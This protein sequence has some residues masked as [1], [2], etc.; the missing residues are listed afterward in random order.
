MTEPWTRQEQINYSVF[1]KKE[2]VPEYDEVWKALHAF[3]NASGAQ[4][5]DSTLTHFINHFKRYIS[6]S[7]SVD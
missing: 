5:G 1:G 2:G 7:M 4:L 3:A 6:A